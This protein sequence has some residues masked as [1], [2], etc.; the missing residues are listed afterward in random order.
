MN[1]LRL[2]RDERELTVDHAADRLSYLVLSFGLLVVVAWRSLALGEASWDLLALV[3]LGGFAG[4]AY[5]LRERAVS[6]R[7]WTLAVLTGAL[8]L[9]LAVVVAMAARA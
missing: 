8:A 6:R 9:G 2:M 1:H 5:R 3:L 4:T 7:W